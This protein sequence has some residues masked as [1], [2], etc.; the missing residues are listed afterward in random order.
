MRVALFVLIALVGVACKNKAQIAQEKSTESALPLTPAA[1]DVTPE[2]LQ[3]DQTEPSIKNLGIIK[4][5]EYVPNTEMRPVN[6]ESVEIIG[7]SLFIPVNFSGGCKNHVFNL[8]HTGAYME[9]MP[10]ILDIY[11]E[12][13]DNGD[14]CR[15][16]ITEK[17][18]FDLTQLRYSN[19][20]PLTLRLYGL[21]EPLRYEY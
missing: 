5:P 3:T 1:L 17:L 7:D 16:L 18:G 11:L 9:S 8:T 2:R 15:A 19:E 20:G 13:E 12:H 4:N 21:R 14:A 6:M 10:P